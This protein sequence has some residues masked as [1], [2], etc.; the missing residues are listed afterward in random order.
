MANNDIIYNRLWIERHVDIDINQIQVS[1]SDITT[2]KIYSDQKDGIYY[3]G[4][5]VLLKA[6]FENPSSVLYFTWHKEKDGRKHAIDTEK[7][8][9]K[10]KGSTCRLAIEKPELMIRDCDNSD[11]GTYTLV[12]SCKGV[13]IYSNELHLKVVTGPPKVTL[14]KVP[15]TLPNEHVELK[16]VIRGFPK[17]F[18]V[19]WKKNSRYIDTNDSKYQGSMNK[20]AISV[21]CINDVERGDDGE[22]TIEVY[23]KL[24][25]GQCSETLVVIGVSEIFFVSGPVVVSPDETI[26]FKAYVPIQGFSNKMWLKMKDQST[27]EIK[28][29]NAKYLYTIDHKTNMHKF[30]ITEA[31]T[32]D[33]AT[34]YF[35]FGGMVSNRI[36]V[37]VDDSGEYS[38]V[39]QGNCLRFFQLQ[40]VSSSAL[41]KLFESLPGNV[42]SNIN[43]LKTMCK[44][45]PNKPWKNELLKGLKNIG[46]L[47]DVDISLMYTMLRNSVDLKEEPV[48]GWG[49]PPGQNDINT[50]D[51]IERIHQSRN[52]IC[53]TDASEIKT[54]VFNNKVLD[55]LGAIKRLSKDNVKLIQDSCIIMNSTYTAWDNIIWQEE[56][57]RT[58][59]DARRWDH[60]LSNI[61]LDD[62][63][64]GREGRIQYQTIKFHDFCSRG[65]L[66]KENGTRAAP[67]KLFQYDSICFMN[68][69]MLVGEKVYIRGKHDIHTL[70]NNINHAY[71]RIGLTNIK[72]SELTENINLEKVSCI[73]EQNNELLNEF[74]ICVTLC[75]TRICTLLIEKK[76]EY[77]YTFPEASIDFPL[78]LAIGPYGIKSIELK[79]HMID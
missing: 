2:I 14:Q 18:E 74:V 45:S 72:P 23:N 33:S 56:L 17:Q 50:A 20:G 48:K 61:E 1:T 11:A 51:D 71:L 9:S 10:Y 70:M 36:S 77:R 32:E 8:E 3:V 67:K 60:L 26:T 25:K 57:K 73:Q 38:T 21:L 55:L 59:K 15:S 19:Y 42:E 16:A 49:N 63:S 47:K 78:W 69:P 43:Q 6:Y 37:K 52:F 58:R 30:E 7:Y 31:E 66:I 27:K 79:G 53:H 12:V 28:C 62:S 4:E 29:D 5:D 46:S 40:N 64:Q 54:S 24:G 76:W 41:R 39:G 44:S 75:P 34:Y 65:I 68:R 13:D 22:Y 35:S